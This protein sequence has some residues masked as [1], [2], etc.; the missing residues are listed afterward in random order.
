MQYDSNDLT[1]RAMAAH[2]RA[3]NRDQ[4]GND[5]DVMEIEGRVYVVLRN[6]NGI[7]N[8]YRLTSQGKLRVLRRWPP[9]MK[10]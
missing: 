5:S 8:V 1:R 6:V 3:G 10:S 2:F 7:L 4:P 9:E